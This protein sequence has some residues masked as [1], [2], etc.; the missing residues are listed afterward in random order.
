MNTA[1]TIAD[2]ICRTTV[3]LAAIGAGLKIGLVVVPQFRIAAPQ[4]PKRETETSEAKQKSA[5]PAEP[6]L[7]PLGR[8][9]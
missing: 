4:Q 9:M 5:E 7:I 6:A 3:Y 8:A 2:T 1:V